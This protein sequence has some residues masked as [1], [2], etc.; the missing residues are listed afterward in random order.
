LLAYQSLNSMDPAT[1][2]KQA[3][4]GTPATVP[5]TCSKDSVC[6]QHREPARTE[7]LAEVGKAANKSRYGGNKSRYASNCRD[8]RM[9]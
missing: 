4:A 1:A 9:Q 6:L 2:E 5:T 8:A 7:T 3:R